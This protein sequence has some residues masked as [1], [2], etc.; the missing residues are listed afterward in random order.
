MKIHSYDI[1]IRQDKQVG[2]VP[3]RLAGT[4]GGL[5]RARRTS[6]QRQTTSRQGDREGEIPAIYLCAK[7]IKRAHPRKKGEMGNMAIAEPNVFMG[8]FWTGW[9]IFLQKSG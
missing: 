8:Y 6:T 9:D 1:F 7:Q 2:C 3:P 4:V 5:H